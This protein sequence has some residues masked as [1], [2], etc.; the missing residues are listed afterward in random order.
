VLLIIEKRYAGWYDPEVFRVLQAVTPPFPPGCRVKLSD[1]T[2]AIVTD[3]NPG[4]P[5][6]PIVRRLA[7]DNWELVGDPVDL[8]IPDAPQI[9]M[10]SSG[11]PESATT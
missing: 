9:Q 10:P 8:S 3:I 11:E 6:Q 1:G 4:T 5:L 2:L 7:G